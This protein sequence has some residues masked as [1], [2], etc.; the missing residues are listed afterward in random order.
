MPT[1]N[2]EP[3]HYT[4][5][6]PQPLDLSIFCNSNPWNTKVGKLL[7]KTPLVTTRAGNIFLYP[8]ERMALLGK[9]SPIRKRSHSTGGAFV[10]P[11]ITTGAV[12]SKS[13]MRRCISVPYGMEDI[14]SIMKCRTLDESLHSAY[15]SD[16]KKGRGIKFGK[17][18]IREYARTLGDNP[19][20]SSGPPVSISWEYNFMGELTIQEY[21][22]TR[23]NR[24]SQMEMVLP[25][26]VRLDMLK[27]D[28]NVTQRQ[29]AEAVRRNVR[30]KNQR[31]TTVNNLGK[32][33]KVE[34]MM[35]SIG[36]KVKRTL[37][38]KKSISLQVQELEAK[39][40][41]AARLRRQRRLELEMQDEYDTP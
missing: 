9:A 15:G 13:K 6:N 12:V 41:E 10:S 28:C 18:G 3:Q 7:K 29:I 19:S 35:E 38:F 40:N 24:R 16:K 33:L 2:C 14:K 11:Q 37:C 4:A 1:W 26:K 27:K 36:R 22:D 34:Q 31:R 25:R 8:S 23:P 30:A 39:H 21:E 32:A 17:I 5:S 20:C